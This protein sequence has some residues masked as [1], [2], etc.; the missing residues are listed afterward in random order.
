[1]TI[2]EAIARGKRE[3][4]ADIASGRIPAGV[5]TFGALHDHVDANE[6]GG[7]CESFDGSDDACR[8]WNTV[9]NTLDA[10]L[11]QGRP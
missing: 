6:Y 8:F 3:I 11:R 1:M 5:K 7:G 4:Q 10:W 9:Q 2:E